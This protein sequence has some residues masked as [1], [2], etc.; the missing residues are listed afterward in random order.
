MIQA[1]QQAAQT[2]PKLKFY[3]QS[4]EVRW[5][6]LATSPGVAALQL[7]QK[8]LGTAVISHQKITGHLKIVDRLEV[9]RLAGQLGTKIHV[10]EAGFGTSEAG[11]F[12]TDEIINCWLK[13]MSSIENLLRKMAD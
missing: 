7:V 6:L 13:Q 1:S 3:V 10:W 12:D 8:T 4:G 9:E 2:R 11:L 5:T